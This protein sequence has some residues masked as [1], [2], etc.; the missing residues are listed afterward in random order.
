MNTPWAL[1]I[2]AQKN[3]RE[4]AISK[5]W[6]VYANFICIYDH[7]Y[8]KV[9]SGAR[10]QRGCIQSAIQALRYQGLVARCVYFL[11]LEAAT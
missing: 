6:S 4:T 3:E 5:F 2:I 10:L 11:L 8:W 1:T 7:I 9:C